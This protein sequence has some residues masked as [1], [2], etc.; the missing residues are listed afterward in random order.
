VRLKLIVPMCCVLMAACSTKEILDTSNPDSFLAYLSQ[1]QNKEVLKNI[2]SNQVQWFAV[3]ES[4][5]SGVKNGDAVWLNIAVKLH[6]VSD[7]GASLAL[8]YAVSRGLPYE[9]ELVLSGVDLGFRLERLC[10]IPFIE[11]EQSVVDGFV[12]GAKSKLNALA[13]KGGGRAEE[14]VK[15]LGK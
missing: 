7:A 8:N 10:T 5:E 3:L 4:I 2:V 1:G 14:C 11:E 6:E 13:L 9:P 15:L 12:T